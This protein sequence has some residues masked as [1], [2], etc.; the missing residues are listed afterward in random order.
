MFES[1]ADLSE[2]FRIHNRLDFF[3]S[4]YDAG[5]LGRLPLLGERAGVRGRL[6][7]TN[8]NARPSQAGRF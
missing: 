8:K 6:E 7:C 1:Y 2:L 5:H 3:R 4:M